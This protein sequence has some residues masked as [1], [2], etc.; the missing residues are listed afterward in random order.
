MSTEELGRNGIQ[1][2]MKAVRAGIEHDVDRVVD[3]TKQL[4]DY[5]YYVERHPW[6]CIG[7]AA[8]IGFL[9]VPQRPQIVTPD[10]DDLAT[11]AK[12]NQLVVKKSPKGSKS[13]SA[14]QT[15]AR[16]LGHLL[17]RATVSYVGQ[18]L[19]AAAERKQQS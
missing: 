16:F 10:P 2:R 6:L 7:A 12:R 9:A 4:A 14:A 11:L 18:K 8:L 15:A 13:T 1:R 5:H 19:G 3:Q 17:V